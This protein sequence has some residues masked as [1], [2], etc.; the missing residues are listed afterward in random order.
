MIYQRHIQPRGFAGE[1]PWHLFPSPGHYQG[2]EDPE[3]AKYSFESSVE[4]LRVGNDDG[5]VRLDMEV[6]KRHTGAKV[7][8]HRNANI[9]SLAGPKLY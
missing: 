2:A 8:R 5:R 3:R 1:I 6:R 9:S 4:D 7:T